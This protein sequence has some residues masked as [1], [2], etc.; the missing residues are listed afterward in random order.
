[1]QYHV[2]TRRQPGAFGL[3]VQTAR[4]ALAKAGELTEYGHGDVL[5]KDILGN[6]L[7][8][9]AMMALAN[10]EELSS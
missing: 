10:E 3:V 7:D 6:I 5:F 8:H 1:M 9:A 2:Y 4:Q